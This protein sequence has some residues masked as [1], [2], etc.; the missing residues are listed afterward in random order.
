MNSCNIDNC[1]LDLLPATRK[2]FYRFVVILH[3]KLKPLN[4]LKMKKAIIL[5]CLLVLFFCVSYG[6]DIKR[7]TDISFTSKDDPYSQQRLKLDI[8]IPTGGDSL[9][10]PVIIWFHGGGLTGGEKF[11]PSQ[12]EG[13]RY[14]VVAPNYRLIPNVG[15][16]ECIDDA[17]EA[18]AWTFENIKNFG[19]DP[20]RIFVSGHSAGGFL[21]SMIGLDKSRLAPYGVDA[22]SIA[23]LIPY[24]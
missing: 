10:R 3:H 22:D 2:I 24:S 17:A 18:V 6:A 7:L 23:A 4:C 13:N 14:I 1:P 19:G 15:V 5:L 8:S 21:T 9:L 11:I 20:A 16:E 12:L